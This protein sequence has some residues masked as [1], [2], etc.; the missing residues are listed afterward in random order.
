MSSR[1]ESRIIAGIYALILLSILVVLF[2]SCS[3]SQWRKVKAHA[4]ETALAAGGGALGV[5]TGGALGLA[6]AVAGMAGGAYVGELN[7]PPPDVLVVQT[8]TDKDGKPRQPL[9]SY[10]QPKASREE[11]PSDG[12]IWAA[13]KA[14][15]WLVVGALILGYLAAHREA[16]QLVLSPIV[17]VLGLA[18]N[19]AKTAALRLRRKRGE[20]G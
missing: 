13:F 7:A 8:S 18:K 6:V 2:H 11:A 1:R 3:A 4:G 20:G 10:Q 15:V 9:V 14:A 12:S 17:L 19:A 16:R 5:F